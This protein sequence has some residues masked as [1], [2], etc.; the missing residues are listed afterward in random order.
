LAHEAAWFP[1]RLA[2]LPGFASGA[3]TVFVFLYEN[4]TGHLGTARLAQEAEGFAF[5][6]RDRSS[7]T[8]SLTPCLRRM[9]AMLR[10]LIR[11]GL[12]NVGYDIHRFGP[13]QDPFHDLSALLADRKTQVT[14][15]VGANIGQTIEAISTALPHAIIH[16]FEPLP[17]AFGQLRQKYGQNRNVHLNNMA[18][19][20]Q[21]GQLELM[22]NSLPMMSSF[23]EPGKDWFG[24]IERRTPVDVGTIDNYCAQN[25]ISRID[26]LKSDTQGFDLE[27]LKGAG[28]MLSDGR[29]RLIFLEII[30]SDMYKNVPQ[31]PQV[32]DFLR[33]K[34][35]ELWLLY[36]SGILNGRSTHT[37]AIYM[38]KSIVPRTP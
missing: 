4:A 18:L 32:E 14:F 25:N 6:G 20:A 1:G 9:T 15:D 28:K 31:F 13:G 16:A 19:G 29:V 38:H 21:P 22:E 26:L 2:A 36:P 30:I 37:D 35:F 7:P 24:K 10:K 12:R 23:L 33:S 34:G 3:A 27:V 5:D 8:S 11:T 17:A